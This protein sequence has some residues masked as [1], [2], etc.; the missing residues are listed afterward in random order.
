M[1]ALRLT[2]SF[3]WHRSQT[4]ANAPDVVLCGGRTR[5][6][7]CAVAGRVEASSTTRCA[8]VG[9]LGRPARPCTFW[10]ASFLYGTGGGIGRGRVVAALDGRGCAA[11]GTA[12]SARTVAFACACVGIFHVS[13]LSVLCLEV[14]IAIRS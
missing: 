7:C 11:A 13:A 4:I 10:A 1:S 5:A 6:P 2:D 14:P 3:A 8:G 9:P 12:R